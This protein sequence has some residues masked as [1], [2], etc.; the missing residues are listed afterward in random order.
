ML[1]RTHIMSI[2]IIGARIACYANRLFLV[3]YSPGL[4]DRSLGS[5][6]AALLHTSS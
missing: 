3:Q 1:K 5:R 2:L 4:S 6:F